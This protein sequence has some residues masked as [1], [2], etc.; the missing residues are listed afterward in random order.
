MVGAR[1]R[2]PQRRS[3]GERECRD[4][5]SAHGGDDEAACGHGAPLELSEQVELRVVGDAAE[6][7]LHV[8]RVDDRAARH[9]AHVPCVA[10]EPLDVLRGAELHELRVDHLGL[11]R[12]C[13]Q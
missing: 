6:P 8:P 3:A 1:E 9:S 5:A 10:P 11:L 12:R 13:N 7:K 4:D 2:I